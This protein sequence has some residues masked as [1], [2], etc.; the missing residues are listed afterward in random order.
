MW[1]KKDKRVKQAMK[2]IKTLQN[3]LNIHFPE[4][5]YLEKP[6]QTKFINADEFLKEEARLWNEAR[7]KI[8]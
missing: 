6:D 8:N 1:F 3:F 7:R 5:P 2:K 4:D